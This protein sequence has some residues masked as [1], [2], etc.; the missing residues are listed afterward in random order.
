MNSNAVDSSQ[1]TSSRLST[2]IN[3]FKAKLKQMREDAH[4]RYVQK[5][6]EEKRIKKEQK[7]VK[8]ISLRTNNETEFEVT[9]K[10]EGNEKTDNKTKNN[11]DLKT[12]NYNET[13]MESICDTPP[14]KD[15]KLVIDTKGKQTRSRPT[16]KQQIKAKSKSASAAIDKKRKDAAERKRRQRER[17][18]ADKQKYELYKQAE[19]ERSRKRREEGKIKKI[20]DMTE[21]EKRRQRKRWRKSYKKYAEK[22]KKI[23]EEEYARK[24]FTP[25]PS[26]EDEVVQN[27]NI[28]QL[29]NYALRSSH[30][31][32]VKRLKRKHNKEVSSLGD[33]VQRYKALANAWKQKYSRLQKKTTGSPSPNT[34]ANN[35][36]RQGQES[37][38]RNLIMGDMLRDSF[39]KSPSSSR[40]ELAKERD[41]LSKRLSPA[42]KHIIKYKMK[43]DFKEILG[44][45]C[46]QTKL[47]GS[48]RNTKEFKQK[49]LSSIRKQ[50]ISFFEEDGNSSCTP[51]KR[52]TL[53][54]RKIKKQKRFLC[55]NLKVLH[56]K[57]V[58]T[59]NKKISYALF[60]RCKPFWVVK[61]KISELDTCMCVY[62]E[63]FN[64]K[65]SKSKFLKLVNFS[66][67][68]DLISS[69]CCDVEKKTCMYRQC[70]ECKDRSIQFSNIAV[71]KDSD[72][73]FYHEWKTVT[74][75]R[76]KNEKKF[77]VK[78]TKKI[79][80][81]STVA[82]L[83]EALVKS[84][85]SFMAHKYRA[86]HQQRFSKRMKSSIQED[87][88]FL[89]IDFSENYQLKYSSET[90]S[91]HF[92]ASNNQ[93][94]L[95][96]GAYYIN[97]SLHD[98]KV[99]TFCTVSDCP[100]HDAA[101][102]WAHLTPILKEIR[103]LFPSIKRLHILSDGP[104]KQYRNKSNMFLLGH[105]TKEM[106][107]ESACYN[108][109]EAGHG[110]SVAD[111]VGGTVKRTADNVVL[112]GKDVASIEDFISACTDT[113]ID[114]SR[115]FKE[116]IE[117]IDNILLQKNLTTIPNTMKLHQVF[118]ES[119]N[120][121][122]LHL[123]YLSCVECRNIFICDHFPSTPPTFEF[124]I[125][126]NSTKD[127]AESILLL[128]YYSH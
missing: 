93:L 8:M 5:K 96:T 103:R 6:I 9:R 79:K 101:A 87:E 102:I 18:K 46:V 21:R 62:H 50:V 32:A 14:K 67:A 74:E 125:S 104:T 91:C 17:V 122:Q 109:S 128:S 89:I 13:K 118:L 49:K 10:V 95:H 54:K 111:G 78:V 38:K 94:T 42:S 106:G 40:T 98:Q 28:P 51:G 115:V 108:F 12:S 73:C 53:T 90:Q 29:Q 82:A 30:K 19:R 105:F 33:K 114:I 100:R 37:V 59:T 57:F 81:I 75:E 61:R 72:S 65:F 113:K 41:I 1:S 16:R 24:Q 27:E 99:R 39:A 20:S 84:L 34:K 83:K 71:L 47:T 60:C 63:N 55:D 3:I 119:K 2:D 117:D 68:S 25:P 58:E 15:S 120:V 4:V 64:L 44:R 11:T 116:E 7:V 92:G 107:F 35:I 77:N 86:F 123:R 31:K 22:V 110:K 70:D 52:D 126:E 45:H 124:S 112:N 121:R 76:Q 56:K 127:D 80:I 66:S 69:L 36:M 26:D 43:E 85:E 88:V 48:S 97:E 23:K